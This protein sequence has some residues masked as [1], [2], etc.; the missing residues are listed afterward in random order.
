MLSIQRSAA[1]EAVR[2]LGEVLRE[3][4]HSGPPVDGC[5]DRVELAARNF[6]LHCVPHSK[7]SHLYIL[8]QDIKSIISECRNLGVGLAMFPNNLAET[9]NAIMKG[10]YL[11]HSSREGGFATE[12][13]WGEA[14][15][16]RQTI[17]YV[18]L[19]NPPHLEGHGMTRPCT[20]RLASLDR[21]IQKPKRT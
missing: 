10:I 12:N 17:L 4:Y 11:Q 2:Q 6:Q 8:I 20:S 13:G 1:D 15:A 18:F 21:S 3:M 5:E 19:L 9:M 14:F 7:S 16:L